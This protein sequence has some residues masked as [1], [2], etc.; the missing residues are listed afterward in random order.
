[1]GRLADEACVLV[2]GDWTH[3]FVHANGSRFHVA[4]MGT[5]PLVLLLHGFPEFWWAWH[6]QMPL[7]ADAGFRA[8]AVDLRGYG[9]TDKPPRG[10]DGFT[11]AAD[12][13]GLIR[14]L[15]ERDAVLVGA[16]A[17]GLIAWTTAAF[18]PR[19]VRRLVVLGAAH[20]LRLRSAIITDPR[21]QMAASAPL[22]KF[23]I[24]RY[25]HTL[26]RDDAAG[27]G[28]LFHA[29]TGPKFHETAAYAE[30]ESRYREAMRIPQAMF[31]A[32][33]AYRWAFRSVLRLHGWRFVRQ[34]RQ[35]IVT[36][37]LQLHG[38]LDVASLPGTALG[39]GR[40]VIAGYEWRM[41]PD[42]GHFPHLEAPDL[43]AGEI[44]RWAKG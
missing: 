16:G 44:I 33:E 22:L 2:E 17:G 19:M 36:P 21:G 26:T 6:E 34:V 9:A 8:V 42:V 23:Q 11:L 5:G 37:T 4:E 13:V 20:P 24:P 25:E 12:V 41:L 10:Y 31:C 27:I 35:P 43:V 30:A 1:V 38:E 15:G 14:A 40:Y 28:E 39:S 29:W 7:I 32:L 18:H 3:R